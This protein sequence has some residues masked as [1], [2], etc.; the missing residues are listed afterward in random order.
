MSQPQRSAL[1]TVQEAAEYLAVS[2]ATVRRL[3][4]SGSIPYRRTKTGG[5]HFRFI[6]GELDR[7]LAT[8]VD[9]VRLS[10]VRR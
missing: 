7:W 1:M 8:K 9:G 3:I 6:P 5:G 4:H 10:E 2:P